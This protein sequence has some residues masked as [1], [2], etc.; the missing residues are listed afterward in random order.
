MKTEDFVL[1]EARKVSLRVYLWEDSQEFQTGLERPMVI[2]CPGGGY[3]FLSD[4]EADTIALQYLAAGFHAAILKYGILEHAV[5][6]GPLR[7]AADAVAFVR[8][9]AKE[10][11]V[12]YE[13][14][15]ISGFSAGGHVAGQLGVFW[16]HKDLLPKYQDNPK[17]VKPK[18]L[19]LCY[20]VLDLKGSCSHMDIG[21]TLEDTIESLSVT[22]GIHPK[23]TPEKVFLFDEKENR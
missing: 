12:S 3:T 20:P 17:K 10:W 4:R 21:A 14:V 19:I 23:V 9:H 6:P 11:L 16:N 2:V 18:G 8:D 13:D 7:D 15:F 22:R 1:D 5:A